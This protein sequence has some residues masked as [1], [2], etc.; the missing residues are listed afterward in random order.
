MPLRATGRYRHLAVSIP[1]C[2]ELGKYDRP[3]REPLKTLNSRLATKIKA[4][5]TNVN[6]HFVEGA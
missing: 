2:K 3:I 5:F 1:A 6:E 4:Q